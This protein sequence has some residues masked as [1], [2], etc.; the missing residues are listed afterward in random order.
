VERP[1]EVGVVASP[2]LAIIIV[3]IALVVILVAAGLWRHVHRDG[4]DFEDSLRSEPS[5]ESS[6]TD[7]LVPDAE[8][9]GRS[10][11]SEKLSSALDPAVADTDSDGIT[12][13][14]ERAYGLDPRERD[15][16]LDGRSD[17]VE[18]LPVGTGPTSEDGDSDSLSNEF[19]KLAGLDPKAADSDQDGLLDVIE[20]DPLDSGE[21]GSDREEQSDA[22]HARSDVRLQGGSQSLELGADPAPRV[23]L[24]A[25]V[26]EALGV[27]VQLGALGL[28]V[29]PM[30]QGREDSVEV[31]ISRA[32]DAQAIIHALVAQSQAPEAEP[33]Q[34]SAVMHVDLAG[35]AFQIRR[36]NPPAGEQVV[37]E[38]ATWEFEVTPLASGTLSLTVS[39]T[40]RIAVLGHG[41]KTVRVPSLKRSFQVDV[42]RIYAGTAFMRRNWQW[43]GTS[44]IAA[45]AAVLGIIFR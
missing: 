42:D 6:A 32:D 8:H 30:R 7:L 28:H 18:L 12:D 40:M 20:W 44:L 5:T 22:V 29:P 35:P 43:V 17:G 10:D 23:S 31:S 14:F 37:S 21:A 41:E 38:T 11:A 16:D 9:D 25:A 36:L 15:S 27:D 4:V 39:A 26:K 13:A 33:I 3:A 45:T 1:K 2:M 19:E 34:T 24:T